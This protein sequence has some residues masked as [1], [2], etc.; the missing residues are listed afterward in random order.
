MPHSSYVRIVTLVI[1]L[2]ASSEIFESHGIVTSKLGEFVLKDLFAILLI[3]S[4]SSTLDKLLQF[5]NALPGIVVKSVS[6]RFTFVIYGHPARVLMLLF[7]HMMSVA[8]PRIIILWDMTEL[9]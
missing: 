2:N 3:V 9:R 4:G 1:L 5:S 7:V 8:L 6:L